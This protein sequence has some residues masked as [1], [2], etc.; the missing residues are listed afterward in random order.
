MPG[1]QDIHF[2]YPGIFWTALG[3]LLFMLVIVSGKLFRLKLPALLISSV[4]KRYYRH[5]KFALLHEAVTKSSQTASKRI[6]W[7]GLLFYAVLSAFISASLA[8]PYQVGKQLPEPPRYRDIMFVVDTSINMI[9]RD[10]AVQGQRVQRMTMM[11]D[12]LSHF[13]DQLQGNRMGVIAFSEQA[14]TL[15]PMTTDYVLLNTQIQRLD[16]ATLTGRTNNLSHAL[17]YTYKQLVGDSHGDELDVRPVVVLLTSVNRPTRDMDPKAVARFYKQ[18]SFYLH[19]VAIGAPD[20]I[21]EEK[22]SVSLIYHPA[23]F[24]LL[25]DVATESGGLFFWAKNTD[26][27]KQAIQT[28]QQASLRKVEAQ[29]RYIEIPLYHWPLLA[30]LVWIILWQLLP[31]VSSLL[32][33]DR[34][35]AT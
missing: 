26:S 25:E 9:L 12:V 13:I 27:L 23:N 2:A 14:Y 18:N 35:I 17:L 28:I 24:K 34:K 8:Q 33:R 11:K 10:Y 30:A 29:A 6:H 19:T 20:Y 21:G 4:A 31:A 22:N 7:A 5:P 32:S 16:S 1:W 15:V 3:V